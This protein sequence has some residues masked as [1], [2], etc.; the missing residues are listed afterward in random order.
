M[1]RGWFYLGYGRWLV[2]W[3]MA[4]IL[5]ASPGVFGR[6][7]IRLAG[8]TTAGV[9]LGCVIC[10]P[11]LLAEFH[12]CHAKRLEA[13]CRYQ[14]ARESLARAVA[15]FPAFDRLERT[16]L[17]KGKLDYFLGG[18]TPEEQSYRA[19]QLTRKK[20]SPEAEA[21][22]EDME[23][24]IAETLD[25]RQGLQ[26]VPA[27][28][29][30]TFQPGVSD[31]EAPDDREGMAAP[32]GL[33]T[34]GYRAAHAKQLRQAIGLLEDL[35]NGRPNGHPV[36]LGQTARLWTDAGLRRYLRAPSFSD[37]GFDYYRQN[38][39]MTGAMACWEHAAKLRTTP[40]LVFYL[41]TLQGRVDPIH[42]DDIENELRPLVNSLSDQILRAEILANLGDSYFAAGRHD[43]SRRRYAESFKSF[44]LP[45]VINY[46]AQKPLG[47]L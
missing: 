13:A 15:V 46:R 31:V 35:Q 36:V 32:R 9:A 44:L 29:G 6:R 28:L 17:L 25:Y 37:S 22:Q 34:R 7:L 11:R 33:Y 2:V 38:Q 4:G 39:N 27:G 8:W 40:D 3:A 47:G 19:F 5:F 12:W 42:P 1:K 24:T 23:W 20:D 43:V 21:S 18:T 45:R 16:W 10:F 30:E 26:T 41:S 14:A